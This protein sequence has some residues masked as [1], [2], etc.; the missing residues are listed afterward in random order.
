MPDLKHNRQTGYAGNADIIG[1]FPCVGGKK[2]QANN[3]DISGW[4]FGVC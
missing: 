3:P 4:M 1:L 2:W